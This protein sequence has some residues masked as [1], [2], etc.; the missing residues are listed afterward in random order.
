MYKSKV[1]L[2][3]FSFSFF[4]TACN[5]NS[6]KDN[7][8]NIFEDEIQQSKPSI[9]GKWYY[10]ADDDR[11]Y[12]H[13]KDDGTVIKQYY[14]QL[15]SSQT[16]ALNTFVSVRG[17]W[18]YLNA[19]KNKFSIG[20]DDSIDNWYN[21]ISEDE[22][23]LVVEI[24]SSHSSGIGLGGITNLL[25]S[26]KKV[27]Y[28]VPEE[29]KDLLGSWYYEQT[30]DGRYMEFKNDGTCYFHY[31][32]S[33]GGVMSNLDGWKINNGVWN[34]GSNKLTITMHGEKSYDYNIVSLTT[35]YLELLKIE[36]QSTI[37]LY[38]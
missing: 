33:N 7:N 3:I 31:Y 6:K 38:K 37:K 12:F 22:N 19:E 28:T 5:F 36:T 8:S 25:K 30:K 20:W 27:V 16:S 17:H 26:A 11:Y 32:L 15:S 21:I 24:D 14:Q 18:A 1:L 34:Y 35:D 4:L 9:I 10:N 23:K 29:I 13:F 2:L